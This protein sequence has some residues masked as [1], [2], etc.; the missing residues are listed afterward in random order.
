MSLRFFVL[1]CWLSLSPVSFAQQEPIDVPFDDAAVT[2][3]PITASGKI[4]VRNYCERRGKPVV[5]L[6]TGSL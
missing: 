2:T 3:S 5:S 4:S 1:F 6:V